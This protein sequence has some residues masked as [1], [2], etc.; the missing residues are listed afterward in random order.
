M[1]EQANQMGFG[2]GEGM[3]VVVLIFVVLILSPFVG[4]VQT[5]EELGME[6]DREYEK[7]FKH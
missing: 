3:T 2:F 4:H 1:G 6:I 5:P 7:T